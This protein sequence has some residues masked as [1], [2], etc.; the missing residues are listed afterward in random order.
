MVVVMKCT[1][2]VVRNTQ[3]RFGAHDIYATEKP[4]KNVPQFI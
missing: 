2:R 1:M 3:R 4:R